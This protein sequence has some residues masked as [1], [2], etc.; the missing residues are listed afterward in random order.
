MNNQNRIANKPKLV[1]RKAK[2]TVDRMVSAV[3]I[4]SM[5][6]F[7]VLPAYAGSITTTGDTATTVT[8]IGNTTDITT[9]TINNGTAFNSFANFTVDAV[10]TVNLHQPS[11]TDALVNVVT[12]GTMNVGGTLN[13]L[14]NGAIGGNVYFVNPDGFIVSAGGVINAGQLTLSTGTSGFQADLMKETTGFT[15]ALDNPTT[16]LFAGQEPLNSAGAIDVYGQINAE[17]LEMRAGG[18]MLLRGQ[19]SVEDTGTAGTISPAVNTDGIPT[20]GGATVEGGVIRLFAGGNLDVEGGLSAKRGAENGGLIEGVS[21]GN[22][23]IASTADLDVAG[24]NQGL[25]NG[26]AGSIV[27]FTKGSA[28]MESG[29]RIDASAI[30]GDG[31]FFSLRSETTAN[32]GGTVNAGSA[33]GTAGEA[34]VLANDV[35][36]DHAMATNGGDLALVGEDTVTLKTGV[37]IST[38]VVASGGNAFVD[39]TTGTA[40]DLFMVAPV[41]TVESGASLLADGT[42]ASNGGIVALLARDRTDGIVWAIDTPNTQAKIDISNATIEG[43][44]VLMTAFAISGNKLGAEDPTVEATQIDA[45]DAQAETNKQVLEGFLDNAVSMIESVLT[46][47]LTT[48]N[49]LFPVQVQVMEADASILI[50]GSNITA[51]GNWKQAGLAA[52]TANTE[53]DISATGQLFSGGLLEEGYSFFGDGAYGL[54][55]L[56]PKDFD[57]ANQS[58]YIQSHAQTDVAIAPKSYGLGVAVAVTDTDSLVHIKN[59]NLITTSGDMALFSTATENM[60]I[61]IAGSAI[62]GVATG[63]VVSSRTLEN[64]LLV[65]NQMVNGTLI[66]QLRSAG[67]LTAQALTGKNHTISN[68]SNAGKDGKVAIAITVS[69]GTGITEAAL[70]GSIVVNGA[71]NIAAETLY[72]GKS[73]TGGA[74]MGIASVLSTAIKATPI[75]QKAQETVQK[76]KS[77]V[78]GKAPT[79]P[80]ESKPGFGAGLAVDIQLDDDNTYATLGGNYHNLAANRALTTLSTTDLNTNALGGVAINSTLRFAE[81]IEGGA[82]YTR[83]ITA[84]MGTLGLLMKAEL[85]AANAAL[86]AGSNPVTEEDLVGLYGNAIFASVSISTMLGETQ[87]ELGG[88][89]TVRAN[90]LDVNALTRYA[91]T[92]PLAGIKAE[93]ASF[94]DAVGEFSLVDQLDPNTTASPPPDVPGLVD[95]FNP[96]TYLTSNNGAKGVA[97]TATQDGT[98][99][100]KVKPEDQKLAVGLTVTYFNTS[101]TTTAVVRNGATV[102]LPSTGEMNVTALEH[103]LFLHVANLPKSNPFKDSEINNAIGGAINIARTDSTV[104]AIIESGADITSGDLNVDAET[105]VIQGTLA[106]AGGSAAK[107]A[108]NAG[109]AVNILEADTFARIGDGALIDADNIRI[110]ALDRSVVV[111][112]AGGLAGSK[113]TAVGASGVVNFVTRD[114]R[115]GIGP[116]VAGAA[117][118]GTAGA[119]RVK[120][121]TLTIEATNSGVEIAV[122]VAGTKVAGSTATEEPSNPPPA[123]QTNDEDLIIP[124]WFFDDEENTA[125]NQQNN[126]DTPA[127]SGG[128]EAGETKPK[129]GWAVSG[130]ASLNLILGNTTE[131]GIAS[132]AKVT[133][134]DS[135]TIKALNSN[136][137]VTVGGAV[138]AG[139]GSTQNNNALAGAFAIHVDERNIGA[140]IRGAEI[141]AGGAVNV[142]SEDK[143]VVVD[144]AIGGAGTSRGSMAVAG[145]VAVNAILG[146][147][148]T[149]IDGATIGGA[150]VKLSAN[151]SSTTVGVAGAI[152]INKDK[153]KGFGVGVGISINVVDR[154]ALT[155]VHGA[156]SLTGSS[157][158]ATADTFAGVYGFGTSVGVGKTGIAGSLAVN[159]ITGGAKV[160]VEGT[161]TNRIA[162]NTQALTLKATEDNQIWSLA[163]ALSKGDSNAFGAGI[164]VNVVTAGTEAALRYVDVNEQSA[165]QALGAVSVAAKSDSV[166]GTIAV[167]GAMAG[168]GTAI[169]AGV[170]VN[171][172]TAGTVSAIEN[173]TITQAESVLAT[174][175]GKREIM[176][177]GGGVAGS[178][179]SGAGGFASTINLL[180][181]ND[182]KV[183]L[184]G[185]TITTRT[186]AITA[187]ADSTG[188]IGSLAIAISAS[189]GSSAAIG[190]AATVNVTTADTRVS[191][192]GAH[193]ES[194]GSVLLTAVDNG[195][196]NSLSGGA[197]GSSSGPAVGAAISANFIAHDTAVVANNA[198]II[199]GDQAVGLSATNN[200]TINTIA[201]ALGASGGS[202][203]VSGSI[204]I[205]DIGNKTE[206]TATGTRIDAGTGAITL[207]ADKTSKI[208]I[209]AGAAAASSS[210]A[211][212]AAVSVA[213]IHDTV[214]ADLITGRDLIGSSLSVTSTNTAKI[215]AISAAGSG[216]GGNA[217]AGSVVYTQIGKPP[218]NGPSVE[219]LPNSSGNAPSGTDADPI[220]DAQADVKTTR[221]NSIAGL[222]TAV[223]RNDLT[224]NLTSADITR[225]RVELTNENVVLPG[226]TI[227][228]TENSATQSLAGAVSGGGTAGFGAALS[229]NLLFGKTEAELVLPAATT[230]TESGSVAVTANQTGSVKTIAAAGAGGGTT[231]GAGSITV[232]VMNR[233]ATA[234]IKGNGAGAGLLTDGA[235]V[236]S[237]VVQSGTIKSLAGAVGVGG[238]AGVGAAIAVNVFSDDASATAEDVTLDTTRSAATLGAPLSG[239][240]RVSITGTQ[241]LSIESIAAAVGGAGTGA[242]A[243]SFAINVA[244]GSLISTLRRSDVL[245]GGLYVT[246]D[247]TTDLFGTAGAVAA[248]GG[249]AVGLGIAS[250][251]ATM[252]VRAD[253]D[254]SSARTLNLIRIE[255]EADTGLAGNAIAGAASGGVS[256]TGSGV[257]NIA[258]NIVEALVRNTGADTAFGGSDLISR[259]SVVMS[260]IGRNRIAMLSG[261]DEAP[262]ANLSFSGG[263]TAGVGASV[264]VNS[265]KNRITT[266]VDGQSRVV[267]L[268]YIAAATSR[269]D[270]ITGT[271]LDAF[272]ETDITMVS[273][274][275]SVGGVAGVSGLFN[276]NFVDDHA[277]V[278]VGDGTREGSGSVNGPLEQSALNSVGAN[279]AN[280]GQDSILTSRIDNAVNSFALG[281]AVGGTAGVGA[282]SATTVITSKAETLVDVGQVGARDDVTMTARTASDLDSYVA[283][284]AGGFVGASASA[285]VN[286]IAS[287][288]LVTA[289]GASIRSGQSN[290]NTAADVTMTADVVND[291]ATFV[292]GIAAGAVGAAGAVQVN[293]FES[294]SKVTFGRA[295]VPL[296]DGDH[297]DSYVYAKRDLNVDANTNLTTETYAASGAGG[298]FGLAVSANITLAEAKTVVEVGA[299]QALT[300][301]RNLSL[302][303]DEIVNIQGSAGAVA[304]GSVGVGASL[305]YAN[306]AGRTAVDV[307]ARAALNSGGNVILGALATRTLSSEVVVG[308]VGTGGLSAA[309]SVVEMGALASDEDGERDARLGD[310]STELSGDQKTGGSGGSESSVESL[311]AF[312]GGNATRTSVVAARQ[313]ITVEG[314]ARPDNV[315]V[316]IGA[317]S[318]INAAGNVALTGKALTSVSQFGGA[319][320]LGA[321]A[322]ISSGVV[323]ANV[324]T[325]AGV[326]VGDNVSIAADG[327]VN[328]AAETG[329]ATAGGHTIDAEAATVAASGGVSVGVGVV[330]SVLS[331]A[332]DVSIGNGVAIGGLNRF[333]AG[334]VSILAK[335]ADSIDSNVYNLTLGGIG[336]VGAVVVDAENSGSTNIAIGS[337]TNVT[338]SRI[339]ATGLS[340]LADDATTTTATGVGSSG[341]IFAGVNGVIVGA[342]NNGTGTVSLNKA[343]LDGTNVSVVNKASG[344]AIAGATGVAVGGYVGIG[345]SVATSKAETTLTTDIKGATVFGSSI[346]IETRFDASRG[347]NSDASA[348]SSSGGLLAGNGASA[349]AHLNYAVTTNVQAD[350]IST[351]RTSVVSNAAGSSANADATGKSGGAVAIGVTIA[352]AGQLDGRTASVQT[353]IRS[354]LISGNLVKIDAANAP[355]LAAHAISGSGGVVSGSGSETRVTG[356]TSTKTDIGT[357]GL[358]EIEAVTALIGASHSATLGSTVDTMSAAA[359][360]ASG[361]SS[362]TN[363]TT[364]VDTILRGNAKIRSVNID[365]VASNSVKRPE[366]GFNIVSGSGGAIDV[367]AMV[368]KVTVNATT[369]FD[370]RGGASIL[371]L[372]TR[373]NAGLFRIGVLTDMALTDRV[374]LDAGGAIAIPIGESS[375]TVAKNDAKVSIG[376]ASLQSV[377]RLTVYA[378]G[379]ANLLAEA[380]TKSYGLAGAASAMTDATYNASHIIALGAGAKLE[381][382]GDVE[383]M[384]GRTATADQSVV[385]N[386]ESRVFNKTA[387]PIPTD[388]AADA[389]A[390]TASRVEIGLGSEVKA[391]EDV[392]L[393]AQGGGRDILGYGRG[394]DL[395]REA[396]A[397]I[398]NAFGSLVGA[399][400]V[401]LD[402]E[403]G[404]SVDIADNGVLVHGM[405]RA[406]SRNQQVLILDVNNQLATPNDPLAEGITWTLLEDVSV[407]NELQNRINLLQSYLDN[408]VLNKDAAAVAAW[409]AE[410]DV[411]QTR[412]AGTGGQTTD[413]VKVD[414]IRAVEGNII[415]RAD[416]VQGSASGTLDAPGD[417]LIKIHVNSTAFLET[418]NLTIAENEGGRILLNDASVVNTN[419]VRILSGNKAGAYDF[420]MISG[421]NSADPEIEVVTYGGASG[422]GGTVVL[423]GDINNFR[424]SVLAVSNYGDMDVR[425][426]IT[427]KVI[428]LDAPTGS[429][430]LGYTPG[431]TDVGGSP[432]AQYNAYFEQ[433]QARY[434]AYVRN[435]FSTSVKPGET[436]TIANWPPFL[437]DG[438]VGPAFNLVPREGRIRAG[439]NVYISA[440]ILNINGLIQAG[441]GSYTV[442][443]DAAIQ[444]DLDSLHASNTTGR[445]L[446]FDPAYPVSPTT[447]R[448]PHISSD[449]DVRVYYNHD[450]NQVEIDN[451]IVQGGRVEIV[452]NIISTGT[453][454]IEALDGFGQISVNSGATT[455]VVMGRIDLGTSELV[456]GVQQGIQGIVRITDTGK[457]LDVG[458][459]DPR[460]RTIEYV[461]EG[462][463]MKVYTNQT[464]TTYIDDFGIERTQLTHLARTNTANDGRV[465]AYSPV[466]N[467]DFV[468]LKAERTVYT[469]HK[470]E[471]QLV[472][473]G[474]SGTTYES[475]ISV[476]SSTAQNS[477]LGIAPYVTTSLGGADYDYAFKGVR[478]SYNQTTTSKVKTYDSVKWW[479]LGSGYRHYTWDVITTTTQLYEHRLKA[480]YPVEIIF[481]GSNTGGLNI[482]TVGNVIFSDTV[483]N[484]VGPTNITSTAGSIL[485]AGRQVV[486]NT[487]ETS[488]NAAGGRIGSIEGAFRL[489][490]NVGAGITAVARD[491]IDLREMSGD[492]IVVAAEATNRSAVEGAA[493]T[494]VISLEAQG[495][496]LKRG[497]A[498]SVLGSNI[499]LVATDGRIG[500][501]TGGS[502]GINTDGGSL[503]A[504]ARLSVDIEETVGD[505]GVRS[506]ISDT[507]GVTLTANDGS[508]LDRNDVETRDKRTE[509]ELLDLWT[510][511]LGLNGAGL[512][513]READQI[514][515]IK[516][517]RK[518]SYIEYWN[519]RTAAADAPQTYVMSAG[520]QQALLDGGWSAMQLSAYIADREALYASWNTGTAFDPNF[521]YL[522]SPTETTAALDGMEWT[523]DQLTR[524]IRSGLVRQ[525]GDTQIRVEDPNV[526]AAGD[527]TLVARDSIGEL[528]TPYVIAGGT[529]LSDADLL[530]IAGADRADIDI[531][532]VVGEIRI[533]QSEDFDFAFTTFDLQNRSLGALT[534]QGTLGS[535]FLGS[536]T[537]A[538]LAGVSG[539]GDV[540]IRIDGAMTDAT[541]ASSVAVAGKFIILESGNDASIG[542][543]TNPLTVEV[544]TNGELTARSGKNVYISAPNGNLPISE[545]YA[546]GTAS[547]QTAGVITDV[548][549]SGLPRI[550]A[551]TIDLSASS[552]GTPTVSFGIQLVE[553]VTG[554]VKLKT[555][556]GDAYLTVA[557]DLPL[558]SVDLAGGGEIVATKGFALIGANT[559]NFGRTSTLKLVAPTGIDLS[560]S[561]GTDATGGWLQINSG[562]TGVGTQAKPLATNIAK[563]SFTGTGTDATPLWLIEKDNLRVETVKQNANANSVTWID[564]NGD[565]SVGTIRSVSTVTLN[566]ANITDGRIVA[567]RTELFAD[568][569]I[570]QRTPVDVTTG[571]FVAKTLNG[572]AD[573]LLRDRAVNVESIVIGGAGDLSLESRKAPVTLLAGPGITTGAGDLTAKLTSLNAYA[574]VKTN[575]GDLVLTTAG[576]LATKADILSAGGSVDI[577]VGRNMKQ[578]AGTKIAA[579]SGTA[580]VDVQGNMALARIETT[581]ASDLALVLNVDGELSVVAD[582]VV[583]LAANSTGALTTMRLGSLAPVGPSGLQTQ[584][585]RLDSVVGVGGQHINE[586]DG[587]IVESVISKNGQVDLFTG[588]ET[589]IRTVASRGDAPRAVTV[590]A[591]GDIIADNAII[592]GIDIGL[593]A[594]GGGLIG[595][596]GRAFMVDTSDGATVKTFARDNL[597][598]TETAGD[599]RMAFALADTG[600]L[601]LNVPNGALEAGIL[602]TPGDLTIVTA[603]DMRINVIGRA[604]VDLADEVALKLVRPEYYGIREA[605]SPRNV[606]LTA[607][608]T[609]ASLF[610]GL[611]SVKETVGLHADNIDAKL[612]D[613]TAPDG[614]RLVINDAT[615]DF[616]EVVDVDVIGDGPTLFF[617]DPFADVRPRIVGRDRSDGILYLDLARI[618]TG[619][620]TH[621]GP[622]FIGDDVV[623]NGDVWFRQRSFDLFA[624][625][626]YREVTTIDDAQVYALNG[627]QISFAIDS[628]IVLTTEHVLV[629]NRKLGGLDLNGGQGFAFE[630]GV[631]T[632]IMGSPFL[633]NLGPAG[634]I[635]PLF[636]DPMDE[637]PEGSEDDTFYIPLIMADA[638]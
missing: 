342:R 128:G 116:S 172:I 350:L 258:G 182:T 212:G 573:I 177:L 227:T 330:S 607:T 135:L 450:T 244:D 204:A 627:G 329:A 454:R 169:G 170:A 529:N 243:G 344:R 30:A 2:R 159:T 439:K 498:G 435:G 285:N 279:L 143:A 503:T 424:G 403:S 348:S 485:T 71:A 137:G 521:E 623:I 57:S 532:T 570:G 56:L 265:T 46:R 322:G 528:L 193:L 130:A 402:I 315:G 525:T 60:N 276:F 51:N 17:R 106:Y 77:Q 242:F 14:K 496:I 262:G 616:A 296:L 394:K 442:N 551:S 85:A 205:G 252:T 469:E 162:I 59:S 164:T 218:V 176:S 468:V 335:R 188:K 129:T 389:K 9:T 36:V 11:T 286:K 234:R 520:D 337:Q 88:N 84:S 373:E 238:S 480:D 120:G 499:D 545:V 20:A 150:T 347:V 78:T 174:A 230:G 632:G 546:G 451:M 52:T 478:T 146:G 245:A 48:V 3:L 50:S 259:G 312:S 512:T 235:D 505:M 291:A 386:A 86:P 93:W 359:V 240:G 144:V 142:S 181:G 535:V 219:P 425:G 405:V 584:L 226:L 483:S 257:G 287:E 151:D 239:A 594:F 399:D 54:N 217:L 364:D 263:G 609:D 482:Q 179:S 232:N 549:A 58:M 127:G 83:G 612:Y 452:G 268:G 617:A 306:F 464:Y 581:N 448:N 305:D 138:S 459:A 476:T 583:A 610:L 518:H 156:S 537:A 475:T 502:F 158:V 346:D 6:S 233:I 585:A 100:G 186:G 194:A 404:T 462:N 479:K 417:A 553:P 163:G 578:S 382:L 414:P 209:L 393:F 288:A 391:V 253:V 290:G 5:T 561:T 140:R 604:Q 95:V 395:Y 200:A 213:L 307:G 437:P 497:T 614:L 327:T 603:G 70:G 398:A 453:G 314:P 630:V 68:V 229:L 458:G 564:A 16:L 319:L 370:I 506:V 117:L 542:E 432:E 355:S 81:R 124:S 154:D 531:D 225:A 111:G 426:D 523:A 266:S 278:R 246:A 283:G 64:Q 345:T 563:L 422:T 332:A 214:T 354:G 556:A 304:G 275:G 224:L 215:D 195:E 504:R 600:D 187:T 396:A 28:I 99:D 198:N 109:I 579:G 270:T 636:A 260:A 492:M 173:S 236:T 418:N 522:L 591:L 24:T 82:G 136:V 527:I 466:A 123:D 157:V 113:S 180:L 131:A 308:A 517:E 590:S 250:N 413:I 49:G 438:P 10:E 102:V 508:L 595:E 317:G 490:Q 160:L 281:V 161:S 629:L 358:T 411:L 539:P 323:V 294:T 112:I 231:G 196:I 566:A 107:I 241:T 207:A 428:T 416:Y 108:I 533:R 192:N 228:A 7:Q 221:D 388:P 407:A 114:V 538:S 519:A 625:V 536:E 622:G 333:R 98:E 27:L 486:F 371:Q 121:S 449:T 155:K 548:V 562:P 171:E 22:L 596:T 582:N 185:S 75:G 115:A 368:S 489:D 89:A 372:G 35:V 79:D 110:T 598:Y 349:Q 434:R 433:L 274:N 248:S 613:D 592:E 456:G 134:T 334:N 351:G 631:E 310:V 580:S 557:S 166:I 190:G 67:S 589:L 261:E 420:T 303:A 96:L 202:A 597:F 55:S 412:I 534:A 554:T 574:V 524:S 199:A 148:E 567:K 637:R 43:G 25:V 165:T 530:A 363:M 430:I 175:T 302:N 620:V 586:V 122:A 31:G 324:S 540:Q 362:I 298:G 633:R 471:E 189:G 593:F 273:V 40:G 626:D 331:G 501:E 634:V 638:G 118:T 367:S 552:I 588:G 516:A 381:S 575:G 474:I 41:I 406:G 495:S 183:V 297:G 465:E 320:S 8:T 628:E 511:E 76:I 126:V 421:A 316:S 410:R 223:G 419:D 280:Y 271:S 269:G 66:G 624:L 19:I 477:D 313:G 577:I 618:G 601:E 447:V 409:T 602:G 53:T 336:G 220:G 365:L 251:T 550:V 328:L 44:S 341:G 26:D 132:N 488:L 97:P 32:V 401:S 94:T 301:G 141:V 249:A 247:A 611:G 29:L 374:K 1:G 101:N 309:I 311:T 541:D 460:F 42:G 184:D 39:P 361:A 494:G 384:A 103:A 33:T 178:S 38:R 392:Y 487:G 605:R 293:M 152:A 222:N 300:S 429:F 325:G 299:D 256:V 356:R 21:E 599:L 484:S 338:Q 507:E 125:I 318:Q 576:N 513:G 380:D 619:E 467:R 378:G 203:A 493:V 201:V 515:S 119:E 343:V 408:S 544:L 145:S 387:I 65:D 105:N 559:I 569:A 385:V 45:A 15:F 91:D 12:G 444:A 445:T 272:G 133:L 282:A 514:A 63:V 168:T 455:T 139:T 379:N 441:R 375:V 369:D 509:A 568:A 23:K 427:A 340:L 491:N 69:V 543:V 37:P 72:F 473:I 326:A 510:A 436:P 18:R 167:A 289:R 62:A 208:A 61:K 621:T 560:A 446:I 555:T 47:G 292:G 211:V 571:T 352:R 415:M 397:E 237:A 149:E 4:V 254:G 472:I 565:M 353:N 104:Q 73:H 635:L 277:I 216:G 463:V 80:G 267:G 206:V 606:D 390:N 457:M 400:D 383:L 360:G 264:T 481:S 440:D 191:A 558:I 615:G 197:A 34:V 90:T 461:R 587:L 526:S 87:A 357:Q 431:I 547:L 153:S 147:T 376:A 470:F 284:V 321:V 295:A 572:S 74:T 339:N 255:A 608:A 377:G 92:N 366:T 13:A 423:S 210:T 443:I 500:G